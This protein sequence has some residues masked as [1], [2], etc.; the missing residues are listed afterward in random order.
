MDIREIARRAEV[1]T[2]LPVFD[3]LGPR[4]SAE[5]LARANRTGVPECNCQP[6]KPLGANPDAGRAAGVLDTVCI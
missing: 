4:K 1:L 3:D 6:A 2:V 5:L